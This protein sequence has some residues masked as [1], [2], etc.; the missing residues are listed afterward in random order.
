MRLKKIKGFTLVELLIVIGLMAVLST[1]SVTF[2]GTLME[3]EKIKQSAKIVREVFARAR[4]LA[5][6]QRCIYFINTDIDGLPHRMYIYMDN[7]NKV[8]DGEPLDKLEGKGYEL[9]QGIEFDVTLST[10]LSKKDSKNNILAF[11]PD[12]SI[13]FSSELKDS[14]LD[15]KTLKEADLVLKQSSVIGRFMFMD[16][17]KYIG[18]IKKTAYQKNEEK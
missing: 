11:Y 1:L 4:S 10:L 14:R 9:K 17:D 8:F 18:K 3:G 15:P 16:V 7:G 12:G 5:S 13:Y 2:L 6:S